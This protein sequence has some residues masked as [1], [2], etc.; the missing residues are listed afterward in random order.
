MW[1]T[2]FSAL[3]IIASILFNILMKIN[4]ILLLLYLQPI[5]HSQALPLGLI[6]NATLIMATNM[7]TVHA[8][9]C[10]ACVCGMFSSNWIVSLNCFRV[11]SSR[12][13]CDL[14]SNA[15]Y[16]TALSYSMQNSSN[17]SFY[18]R[19]LPPSIVTPRA[20]VILTSAG[21][22]ITGLYNTTAGEAT[23]AKDGRYSGSH[24]NPP[25]AIDR[26][27]TTKYFNHG[28][29]GGYGTPVVAPGVGTGFYVTPR[30]SNASVAVALRFATANDRV[31][32]DPLGV[33]L[34][35]TNA[36]NLD[37]G[38]SWRL[39]YNGSTGISVTPILSR[40]TYG[41]QQNFSNT[42]AYR[43]YRLL[44]TAQR[45]TDDAVQYSEVEIIGFI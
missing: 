36:T 15:S 43:S 32:R 11:N 3:F 14:F 26:N 9:A 19:Q 8:S 13:Q 45:G 21:D 17:G 41:I 28:G 38:S 16:T 42:V 30:A 18:F 2:V 29:R 25:K 10:H 23:G 44:I 5:L 31:A 12:V 22:P 20:L 34:E 7:S 33:T 1:A 4:T 39:I 35:G 27:I 24:E 6:H 40:L 37:L